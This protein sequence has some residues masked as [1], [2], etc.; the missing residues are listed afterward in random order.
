MV[1]HPSSIDQTIRLL[2]IAAICATLAVIPVAAHGDAPAN[3]SKVDRIFEQVLE[4]TGIPGGALAITVDGR[5]VH[6]IGV[7]SD[8]NNPKR[9]YPVA[10]CTK[11]MTAL[12]VM[13]ILHDG[14]ARL[15]ERA[16]A[17]VPELSRSDAGR[18][19]TIESLLEQRSGLSR[20]LGQQLVAVDDRSPGAMSRAISAIRASD[21]ATRPGTRFEYS[22]AN[23]MILGRTIKRATDQSYASAMQRLVFDPLDLHATSVGYLRGE[24][25]SRTFRLPLGHAL[26]LAHLPMP[27]A[28]DPA[29]NIVSTAGDLARFASLYAARTDPPP[30]LD[31]SRSDLDHQLMIRHNHPSPKDGGLAYAFGWNV[32]AP[33]GELII[34]HS[35]NS[36]STHCDMAVVLGRGLAVALLLNGNARTGPPAVVIDGAITDI[37]NALVGKPVMRKRPMSNG[38][39]IW[40]LLLGLAAVPIGNWCIA[41]RFRSAQRRIV[42]ATIEFAIAAMIGLCVPFAAGAGWDGIMLFQPDLATFAIMVAAMASAAAL[43]NVFRF[44]RDRTPDGSGV[45]VG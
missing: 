15:D 3:Y 10:S 23:Y 42:L 6:E 29:G 7:G 24:A 37:V 18:I 21:F 19:I 45:S 35:G 44:F 5:L 40:A 13:R 38:L 36:A 11:P 30:A 27:A 41:S 14:R 26:A 20:A 2:C 22:N 34:H 43:I 9:R 8:A 16:I 31:M 32:G 17:L 33:D 4:R 39:V 12:A 1:K 28:Y 25:E